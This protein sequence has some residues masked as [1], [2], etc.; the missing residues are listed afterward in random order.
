MSFQDPSMQNPMASEKKSDHKS[1]ISGSQKESGQGKRSK[2]DHSEEPSESIPPY[3][4]LIP[5]QWQ[6]RCIELGDCKII[7][8]RKIIQTL[9]YL[10]QYQTRETICERDTNRLE[11][12]KC[13]KYFKVNQ[14]NVMEDNV[15]KKM[16]EYNP[17]GPK[18]GEYKEY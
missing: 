6:E 3:T 1:S 15:Y 5:E 8:F 10:C 7:K 13:R 17:F 2:A 11:W 4:P 18:E 12:K 14:E 16:R 9:F